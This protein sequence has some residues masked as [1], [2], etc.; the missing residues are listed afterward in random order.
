M[1]GIVLALLISRKVVVDGVRV[2]VAVVI[3]GDHVVGTVG[4]HF[5]DQVL[6]AGQHL[7]AC[8]KQVLDVSSA[9]S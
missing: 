5:L 6:E 4:A 7:D 3:G 9:K 2:H 1:N 8:V